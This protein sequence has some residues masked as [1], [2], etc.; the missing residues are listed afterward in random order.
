VARAALLACACAGEAPEGT[1]VTFPGSAVG[2]EAEL[3]REQ[4]G[5]F[6]E[7]HPDIRVVQR[8]TPDAADQRHQLYVQ[9]LNAW[10]DDPDIL[11][12]DV[13]WTPEFAAAGWVLPLSRFAPDTDDFFPATLRA[14]TWQGELHALPWFVD[15]GMLYWRSDLLDAPPAS[16]D[17][18]L[19]AARREQRAGRVRHG[20]VWQG[21]RYEGLVTVFV[22]ML[23]AHGGAILDDAGRVV[24][25]S[26]AA[27]RALT[28]LTDAVE[29]GITPREALSWQEEQTRFAFQNGRALFMRNWPYAAPLL[30]DPEESSVAG[31]FGVA[32]LPPAPGGR[33]SAALGGSQLAINARSD[34]PEAAWEVIAYL[35]HPD[36]MRERAR[37][38]GQYPPR[39]SLYADGSLAD[40]LAIP[41]E[42]VRAIIE[43]AIPRPV[44][45]LYTEL[46]GRLQ[47][48]L[49]RALTGQST[50]EDALAGAASDLRALL[51]RAD[52]A[53]GAATGD[54]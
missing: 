21:A 34:V 22:E 16:L 20:W 10:A 32:A 50:P 42:R 41:P 46:S 8:D 40:A 53:P 37:R 35:A 26:P 18:V 43:A 48:R 36:R 24:V 23:A 3:L 5:R 15:V 51:E 31:A 4:L 44:T 13:I 52:L 12:L 6:M 49:H 28:A 45:P 47:V 9:W 25:D 27:V 29:A 38:L 30:E 7:A 2:E 14:N 39:P 17:E 33:A 19:A 54:G 11:Q 1:V